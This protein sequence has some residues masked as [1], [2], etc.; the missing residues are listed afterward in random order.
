MS[1]RKLGANKRW[2]LLMV[3]AMFLSGISP[4]FLQQSTVNAQVVAGGAPVGNGFVINADDV[5]FIYDQ[6]L[7]AQDHA[8]APSVACPTCGTLLGQGAHQVSDPQLPRGLRTVDGSYNNLVPVPDQHLFGAADVLFP[9]VLT[10]NFRDAEATPGTG[11]PTSYKQNAGTVFDSQPRLISN[12]IVDQTTTINPPPGTGA[13]NPAAQ[14]AHDNPCGSGGFVCGDPAPPESGDPTGSLFI[15]NIT[16]DFGLSAPF[17]LMFT[18]FGQFFD[19]GLDL[20]PKSGGTVII[21]LK[22]DDPLFVAGS[23]TN[24]MVMTRGELQP[25]PDGILG[26]ADDI[27]DSINQTTPWVDQ[28]QTYTSHPSHQVFLRQYVCATNPTA[29]ICG[30]AA[31][32]PIPDGKVLDGDHCAPRGTGFQGDDIC[33]I[34]NWGKVK[35]Q[36]AQKLGIQFLDTDVLN[37]PL[38]LTDPYGHFKPGPHGFAQLVLP[39]LAPGGPNRLLEGDPA[40]NGGKGVL[41]DGAFR[42]GHAFLNDIAHNA[43]PVDGNGVALAPDADNTILDFR[44]GTQAPGTYDDELLA[45]HFVTGDGRGNENI[46]LSTVHQLFHAEH[47]RIASELDHNINLPVD[48]TTGKNAFG[49][50]QAEITAWHTVHAGSGWGYGERLFQAARFGTEMQYQHLVFEEFARKMQPLINAFLGGITSINGAISAEFA[51]TVYRLGHSMLPEVLHRELPSAAGGTTTTNIRLFNAFLNPE[52]FNVQPGDPAPT[53][54]NSAL[55]GTL[56]AAQAAGSLINGLSKQV[57][58]ELDEFVTSSVR[59]TLVGLPL[60]LPAINIARGRSEGI[61]GLNPAR[62][63]LFTLTKNSALTPY[64]TW[65]DFGQG[66]RHHE[67][68][69]N[70]IAAYG[71]HPSVTGVSTIAGKRAAATALLGNNL[72]MFAATPAQATAAGCPDATCGLDNIDFWIG[73]LAER[74]AAFGGLLGSTFNYIFEKQLEDLQNG[75]RFYYLQRTDGLNIRFSLEG[76]SLAEL[77]RRNTVSGATMSNVFDTADFNFTPATVDGVLDPTDPNS[78]VIITQPDGTKLFFDPLHRGKNV[79]FFGGPGDDRFKSDIGD[80]SLYGNGGNDRLEGND[81]ND[82]LIGGDGD[83]ILFGGNGDDVLKGGPGNDALSS[84]PGFGA[85]LEIGG[86]GNDFMVGGDDG[87]EYFGGQGDDVIVDGAMRAEGIFGGDGDDW[88]YDGDGHDGGIFGDGGNVFDL[89]A[90]L[91]AVGGDDVEGGGPGQDNHFGEGGDDIMLMSEGSNKFFGDYGWDWITLRGWN[92]PEFIE[93]DLLANPNVALNF[94]DLRNRYRFVDGASGWNLDDH[95]AGSNNVLCNPAAEALVVECLVPGMEL[96]R[97][98]APVQVPAV[99]V[100]GQFNIR[101]GSGASKIGGLVD[102]MGPNG[103]NANLD[104]P[105][106]PGTLRNVKNVGFMGGDI[107]LGGPG[108]DTLEGKRGDDLI[109]GD[110]WLNVQLRAVMNDGTIKLVDDPRDLVQDVFSDPQRLNPGNISII[111]TIVTPSPQPPPDCGAVQPLNCDTA[112]FNFPRDEYDI[113]VNANGTVTVFHNPAK[114]GGL[115]LDEGTDTLRNIEQLKFSDITIP[116]PKKLNTVPG[117]KGLTQAAA[118]TLILQA[119][120]RVG[121][122]TTANS[123]VFKIGTVAAVSPLEGT[124]LPANSPVDLVISLGTIVPTVTD[125]PLG[126]STTRGTALNLIAEAGL[127]AG[128]ITQQSSNTVPVGVV[129]SQDPAAAAT[130]EVGSA[131]N[132]VVSSG[133]PP[134][135]VPNVVGLTQAA[136]TTSLT[137]AGL[138]VGAITFQPS[139]TVAAGIVISETPTAGTSLAAGSAVALVVSQG[140]APTIATFVSR[141]ATTPNTTIASPAFAV[142]GNTLLVAFISTDG[143]ATGAN[144]VVNSVNNNAS[145]PALTWTRA[146]RA[147]TQHG[148]SEIWWAFS[149]TARASMTVTGVLSQSEIASMT[150]VGFQGAAN[151]L[152]GAATAIANKATGVA[153]NPSLTITTTRANSWVFGVGNDWDNFEPIV[154]AAGSTMVNQSTNAITDT[155]WTVR[156]TNPT[157]L[158]GV[159]TTVGVTGVGTD[160]YNFAVI[161][162]RQP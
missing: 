19:H 78:P 124:L 79:S 95:I 144:V 99:G 32:G 73:G 43:V 104:A 101:G 114:I 138:T 26:T 3:A 125:L 130:V 84:G 18:F 117:V 143:P 4:S 41:V 8:T 67:S 115:H 87:V 96:V 128:V 86:D 98:T 110:L 112:V 141:N 162:I 88:I 22:A 157:A 51:H 155:L 134:V 42:T 28:N 97:G 6:I 129:I 65:F 64:A 13:G 52:S 137:G 76:N 105:A 37:V 59:N 109:D 36:A 133:R 142:Q 156:S 11:V 1:L 160:R 153:G 116:T 44:T 68:L 23:Q 46:M 103:F 63:Q 152:A 50:T 140:A 120:L 60:D 35:L 21:P 7:V 47:N 54:G 39:P 66:L 69:V 72:F 161:E 38:V 92:A 45:S 118:T 40:A 77:A 149:P 57:G 20:V 29:A 80:D 31:G 30:G 107:L 83:D 58:N 136:A 81:G 55:N 148:T 49:L 102:L 145:A 159:P 89:L 85:D 71:T 121:T 61:P 53:N 14:A 5:R 56:T 9:R 126:L 75:D 93:L 33:N 34:G 16:P 132:L 131:V 10:P 158:A 27:K 135:T 111:R 70:F 48:P 151:S 94:N 82:T 122:V 15:P 108:S 154:A 25:G 119:G 2:P 100:P 146:Q 91:S 17:N 12:L 106:I 90:G 62:R 113:A 74:P 127:V 24:F 123:T 139:T 147:N 150:V